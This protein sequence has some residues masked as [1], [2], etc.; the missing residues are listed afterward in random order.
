MGN[1]SAI[2]ISI[3]GINLKWLD[4]RLG[5]KV[6]YIGQ[7]IGNYKLIIQ[8]GS[9]IIADHTFGELK[10][11][12]ATRW[13][14]I[15]YDPAKTDDIDLSVTY[16]DENNQTFKGVKTIRYKDWLE[17]FDPHDRPYSI[18]RSPVFIHLLKT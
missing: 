10:D 9:D 2:N 3:Y 8:R 1:I 7:Y 18:M 11:D 14:S 12:Q 16:K 17:K 5:V 13:I 4:F 15:L 6:G